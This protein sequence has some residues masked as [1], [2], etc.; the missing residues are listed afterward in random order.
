[1]IS[2]LRIELKKILPYRTFWVIL[3]LQ[4]LLMYVFFYARGHVQING[5]MAGAE[6]YQFP[7]IWT[8]IVYVS[9]YLNLIP[10][11]LLL[12]LVTDEYTFRTLRQQIIDGFSRADVVKGKFSSG[13]LLS[14]VC[15]LF[16]LLLGLGF[17]IIYGKAVDA[18]TMF[19]GIQALGYYLL[20]L[21]GYLALAMFFGFLIKKSGLAIL[22]FMAYTLIAEPLIHWKLPDAV[23]KFMPIK[24]M[25]SLTPNPNSALVQMVLGETESL[26]PAQALIPVILYIALFCF[27]SYQ[28]LRQRD[29]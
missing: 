1:M 3:G 16:A 15:V 8:H 6:L 10:C 29:L 22:A 20:Q 25:A 17:G 14:L 26:T 21:L 11:I 18:G 12:I 24:A 28:L 2:L 9:S 19:S 7:K 27:L 13:V 23:D 5:Q 4:L